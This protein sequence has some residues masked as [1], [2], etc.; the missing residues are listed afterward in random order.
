VSPALRNLDG[1]RVRQSLRRL[2]G[3]WWQSSCHDCPRRAFTPKVALEAWGRD[4]AAA[5]DRNAA[6]R[7]LMAARG[8]PTPL[9]DSF[10]P[11][12]MA[13]DAERRDPAE[14]SPARAVLIKQA[15][16]LDADLHHRKL[17][18]AEA[19]V[20]VVL[21]AL[22]GLAGLVVAVALGLA[23]WSAANERGLV[24]SAFSVPPD[25]AA[26]GI[27]GQV[28]AQRLLDKLSE[29]QAGTVSSRAPSTFAND[30]NGDI[31]V[32]IPQ[33][34]VSVGELRHLL[35]KW[36]GHQTEISGEVIRSPAGLAITARTGTE[37]AKPHQGPDAQ[38]DALIQQAAEDIYASTQPY[39]YAIFLRHKGDPDSVA[40]AKAILVALSRTGDK[41]DRLWAFAGLNLI[42][43]SEG[44][45][46]GAIRATDRGIALDPRFNLLYANRAGAESG[47]GHD[48]A[49]LADNSRALATLLSD[50]RR[51]MEPAA[52]ARNEPQWRGARDL[53]L[54]DYAGAARSLRTAYEREPN[55]FLVLTAI[56]GLIQA[57][58]PAAAREMRAGL[59][60]NPLADALIDG[61]VAFDLED[62]PGVLRTW[63]S[64][65]FKGNT[66]EDRL[67]YDRSQLLDIAGALDAVAAAAEVLADSPA[68]YQ[69]RVLSPDG[70]AVITSSGLRVQTDPLGEIDPGL[71]TL[72]VVGGPG[73]FSAA[74]SPVLVNW[75]RAQAVVTRRVCSVCTGTFLLAEAG[76]LAG[77][78]VTTHWIASER[79]QA[80][81]PELTVEAD[82]IFIHDGQIWTSAGVTAGI[83]LALA[84]IEQ[85]LGHSVALSVAR[86]L[87]VF[88][89]RPG[90][91]A[92][93]S[94]A[95]ALQ[96]SDQ[97]DF[98]G[99]H[100]WMRENLGGDLRVERL[101]SRAGMTARTFARLYA[102]RV[103][104]TPAKTVERLRLEAARQALEGG[105]ASFKQIARD[106]G[107]G[108]EERMRR[109]F[110]RNLDVTPAEYRPRF[111]V[112]PQRVPSGAGSK[113]A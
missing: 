43:Q 77:R 79:L 9:P 53:G 60:P 96:A 20:G 45:N 54:C 97:G 15:A 88:V 113:A 100:D 41:T 85:D 78:R 63:G 99:L 29:M 105:S 39:R 81:H 80:E 103:G 25:L 111:S 86:L 52:L 1:L 32:E 13:L 70:G 82:S 68:P 50:G 11:L 108:D 107:F 102:S 69:V 110:V 31:K 76:L 71:D 59:S 72:I 47:L 95:L 26:R 40:K 10:D 66:P 73:V 21:R 65:A 3:F 55:D 2:A 46:A 8:K 84:L 16:L 92:Q 18:I 101:A 30:W 34:G 109:A 17:Q 5:F 6:E 90:G 19:R 4:L 42:L 56:T 35:V 51:Y 36:L 67:R 58:E 22:A 48:E 44:D 49:A 12:E 106:V 7:R 64:P 98:T 112:Y 14:D 37:A 33:T 24:V 57:H 27:T 93:F 83:D 61:A 104:V 91:Q 23:V 74:Q 94:A 62:W 87:V 28:V 89:K 38:L 75:I